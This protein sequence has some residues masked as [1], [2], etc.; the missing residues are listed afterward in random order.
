MTDKGSDSPAE[1]SDR[2]PGTRTDGHR[3]GP[4]DSTPQPSDSAPSGRSE[5]TDGTAAPT[6]PAPEPSR[7]AEDRRR[8]PGPDRSNEPAPITI[9]EDGI[10]RWFLKSNDGTVVYVRDIATSVGLVLFIALVLFGISGVWPPLV[11]VESGSM[12]PNME[13]GDMIFVVAEDRFVGD[14]AIDGTGIVTAEVGAETDHSTF[15]N[16]GDVII[17]RPGGSETKTPVIHRAQFWVEED[18]NWV[19][20]YADAELTNGQS[21][22]QLQTCPAEYD[23]FVTHGDANPHYD[24][25]SGNS[26]ADTDVVKPEW[27][28]G[29]AAQR[30]PWLGHIRL[31]VDEI[32]RGGPSPVEV[33]PFAALAGVTL[34]SGRRP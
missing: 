34:L 29:K 14:G 11:A 3:D 22:A 25:L 6:D 15:G 7:T 24:Q 10:L 19:E 2:E 1:E 26:G 17:F 16:P 23:G 21:C 33:T 27:V 13:R 8:P 12:E 31:T 18:E 28:E 32:L 20:K 5:S 4:S 9:E 30:I